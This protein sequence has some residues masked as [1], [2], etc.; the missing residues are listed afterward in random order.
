MARSPKQFF[1]F[2]S[3][4]SSSEIPIIPVL[5]SLMLSQKSETVL[6]FLFIYFFFILFC[7]RFPLFYLSLIFQISTLIWSFASVILPLIPSKV[8]SFQLLHFSSV[9]LL[10][11]YFRYLLIFSLSSW[12]VTP[13]FFQDLGSLYYHYSEFFQIDCLASLHLVIPAGFFFLL[14]ICPASCVTYF[15]VILFCQ[16]YCVYGLLSAG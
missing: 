12:S 6:I 2:F 16:T 15:F 5:V 14:L 11:S 1:P 10:F 9:C 4:F 7:G 8:F 13:F 3:F